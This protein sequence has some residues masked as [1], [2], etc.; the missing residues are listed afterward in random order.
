MAEDIPNVRENVYRVRGL[1]NSHLSTRDIQFIVYDK[2]M[3]IIDLAGDMDIDINQVMY[4]PTEGL[5]YGTV[6]FFLAHYHKCFQIL[7][8][9]KEER[10]YGRLKRMEKK[11]PD[12]E[13]K[14]TFD[15]LTWLTLETENT[16][17]LKRPSGS[18]GSFICDEFDDAL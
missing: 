11:F 9:F 5:T 2:G 7:H 14:H 16:K 10:M 1:F 12:Y 15:E 3:D 6:S 18:T 8:T 13:M 17:I 4:E